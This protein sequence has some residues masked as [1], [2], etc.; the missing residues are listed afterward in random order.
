MRLHSEHRKM[1][2]PTIWFGNQLLAIMAT[3]FRKKTLPMAAK[4]EPNKQRAGW[5]T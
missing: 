5:S 1:T 2:D 4:I 3:E